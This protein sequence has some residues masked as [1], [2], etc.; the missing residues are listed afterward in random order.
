MGIP[1]NQAK[2]PCNL[3]HPTKRPQE[4]LRAPSQAPKTPKAP[5]LAPSQGPSRQSAQVTLAAPV[6]PSNLAPS[7]GPG[8]LP[9]K[10]TKASVSKS[11]LNIPSVAQ[12]ANFGIDALPPDPSPGLLP[13][14]SSPHQSTPA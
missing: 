12:K 4:E 2:L 13:L 11:R 6:T 10:K 9:S 3:S 1:C 5:S 7:L 14:N 8:P